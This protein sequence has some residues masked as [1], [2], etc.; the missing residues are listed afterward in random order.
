[1]LYLGVTNTCILKLQRP[2]LV[3]IE[4]R[5]CGIVGVVHT[6][7]M[8]FVFCKSLYYIMTAYVSISTKFLVIILRQK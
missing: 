4:S 7:V 8:V 3:N 5:K 2:L 6:H 1:M